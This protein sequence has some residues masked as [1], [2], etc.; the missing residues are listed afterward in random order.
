MTGK[1]SSAGACGLA[2][3]CTVNLLAW[4]LGVKI[5]RQPGPLTGVAVAVML[6]AAIFSTYSLIAACIVNTHESFVGI[7]QM[8]PLF[9]TSNTVYPIT[10]MPDWL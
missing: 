7:G 10:I 9:F 6:G 2:H 5:K 3:L 1:A 8:M 4:L